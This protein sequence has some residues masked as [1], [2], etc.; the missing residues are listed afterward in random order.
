LAAITAGTEP[1]TFA[2]AVKDERWRQAMKHKI[3]ALEHN[4]TWTMKHHLYVK[5]LEEFILLITILRYTIP[6]SSLCEL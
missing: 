1:Q 3:H 2:E 5:P 6:Y 4:G